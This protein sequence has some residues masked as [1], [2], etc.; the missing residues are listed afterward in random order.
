MTNEELIA[1]Q[2][3]QIEELRDEVSA[4]KARA[5]LAVRHMVCMG[6]PLNDNKLRYSNE[7]L[8]TFVNIEHAL[9]GVRR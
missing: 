8:M 9:T 1:R 3:K 2:A 4:L 6:G 5:D 7:Q